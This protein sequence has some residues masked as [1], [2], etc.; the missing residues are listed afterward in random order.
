MYLEKG[1]VPPVWEKLTGMFD[2]NSRWEIQKKVQRAQKLFRLTPLLWGIRS[3][4]GIS[5]FDCDRSSR[6]LDSLSNE[7]REGGNIKVKV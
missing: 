1:I 4:S 2:F 6:L 5:L 7:Q 3:K